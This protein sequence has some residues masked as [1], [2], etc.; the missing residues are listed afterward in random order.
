MSWWLQLYIS[1]KIHLCNVL[2]FVELS[3]IIKSCGVR[4][5]MS[6][7]AVSVLIL[8]APRSSCCQCCQC[9][10]WY[11]WCRGGGASHTRQWAPA[12]SGIRRQWRVCFLAYLIFCI[13]IMNFSGNCWNHRWQSQWRSSWSSCCY[14]TQGTYLD[15]CYAF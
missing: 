9:C 14:W 15:T 13:W 2:T 7:A 10:Q 1:S 5:V 8:A 6:A 12:T 3:E 11:Q 4:G